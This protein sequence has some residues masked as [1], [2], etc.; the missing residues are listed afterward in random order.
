MI[1]SLRIGGEFVTDV[2]QRTKLST[3][4]D[5][6]R[7]AQLCINGPLVGSVGR[8]GVEHGLVVRFGKCQRCLDA[9]AKTA[10]RKAA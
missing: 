9:W 3:R 4:R 6:L 7:A 8:K 1:R 2:A 10:H 5:S